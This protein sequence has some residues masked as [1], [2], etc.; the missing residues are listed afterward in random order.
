LTTQQLQLHPKKN[1]LKQPLTIKNL[2]KILPH[3]IHRTKEGDKWQ[4]MI[5]NK[6]LKIE[7]EKRKKNELS[8]SPPLSHTNNILTIPKINTG[9]SKG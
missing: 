9:N 3:S 2:H 1:Q 7:K 6:T 8:L 5:S 4:Y